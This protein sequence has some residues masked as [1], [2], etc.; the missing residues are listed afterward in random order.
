MT[1]AFRDFL[2]DVK[3]VVLAMD[4]SVS[5]PHGDQEGTAY[6]GHFSCTCYPP[7]FLFNQFGDLERAGLRS[8]P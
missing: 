5:P 1:I 8:G 7:L 6:N 4:S 3:V 2:I